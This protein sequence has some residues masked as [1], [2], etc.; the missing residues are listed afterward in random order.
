M[1]AGVNVTCLA[2]VA[3]DPRGKTEQR[4]QIEVAK[5]SHIGDRDENQDRV[6]I[7]I[8]DHTA[9]AIVVDGMGGHAAGAAAAITTIATI[10]TRFKHSKQPLPFPERFLVRA[11]GEAHDAVVRM[12]RDKPV[13][14]RPRATCAIGL[15]QEGAALWAHVGDSRVYLLRE[16]TVVQRTR[17]HTHVEML[18]QEGL[19]DESE[20]AAH[21]MRSFV[22]Q[23]LGGD[24]ERPPVTVGEPYLLHGGDTLFVC[25][26]GVWTGLA[27]R[28]LA[29]AFETSA[30]VLAFD[31]LVEAVVVDAV[32]RNNPASD[33]ASAAAI[34]WVA[35]DP[36]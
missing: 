28:E 11:I 8:G 14:E 36:S 4:L 31:N 9:L 18:L 20:I 15:I 22:D 3:K 1:R 29:A 2:Q 6:E 21:P 30:E 26:D 24:V 27:D 13:D 23:C 5:F 16:D 32:E 35:D 19:L 25:S 7:L 34:R 12:G 10:A 33:N 17:D